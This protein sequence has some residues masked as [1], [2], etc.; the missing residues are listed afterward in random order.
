MTKAEIY[1][2]IISILMMVIFL[3]IFYIQNNDIKPRVKPIPELTKAQ[4]ERYIELSSKNIVEA[5]RR[6][7]DS[8]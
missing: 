1:I 6:G 7:R 8:K 3:L 4:Y 2:G 5:Y